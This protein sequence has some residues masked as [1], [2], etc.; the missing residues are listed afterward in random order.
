MYSIYTFLASLPLLSFLYLSL[1]SQWEQRPTGQL[2][3]MCTGAV[4]RLLECVYKV[5]VP[6]RY[7]I[8]PPTVPPR[9]ELMQQDEL[10]VFRPKEKHRYKIVPGRMFTFLDILEVAI[11]LLIDGQVLWAAL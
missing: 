8:I 1:R 5:S 9:R 4:V 2:P 11:V 3:Y 10:G 7:M 6:P